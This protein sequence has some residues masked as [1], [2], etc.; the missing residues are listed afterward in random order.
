M[1]KGEQI[2][3]GCR[4][5]LPYIKQ[6]CCKQCGKEILREEEE[7]CYDCRKTRHFYTEGRALF[8]YNDA[9]K[10]SIEAFKYKNRQE[11]ARFYGKELAAAYQKQIKRWEAEAIIPVPIHKSRYL[12]RGYNQA[13]LIAYSLAEYTGLYVEERFLF[14]AK[15]TKAQKALGTK[16]RLK[17]LQDAFHLKKSM[18]QY[19]KIILVD[20]IY[21]TGS[22]AD[23]CATVLKKGGVEQI[24]LLCLCIGSGI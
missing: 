2:C 21:T 10:K 7:Y 5:K 22:T 1:P 24:Y 11:Y 23:A 16:D 13:A 17:N 12:E 6:P 9:M 8:S 15:K 20:D 4:E 18:V 14:R 19:K 3:V